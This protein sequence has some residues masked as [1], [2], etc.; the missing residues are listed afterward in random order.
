MIE[1]GD[2]WMKLSALSERVSMGVNVP[3]RSTYRGT[4]GAFMT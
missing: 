1:P 4:E 2:C 3:S